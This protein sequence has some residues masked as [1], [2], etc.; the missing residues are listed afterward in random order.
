MIQIGLLCLFVVI[1]SLKFL[2]K[3]LMRHD[4]VVPTERLN[5]LLAVLVHNNRLAQ[6]AASLV[7]Q[8]V[9]SDGAVILAW[10][11]CVNGRN[12]PRALVRVCPLH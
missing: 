2:L 1:Y 10:V 11:L 5:N 3:V 8:P 6:V 4:V 12:L 7:C 9:E